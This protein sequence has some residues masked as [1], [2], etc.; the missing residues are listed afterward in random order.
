MKIKQKEKLTLTH[1]NWETLEKIR[2]GVEFVGKGSLILFKEATPL[3]LSGLP[4][5][6]PGN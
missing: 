2:E 1:Q 4:P 5:Q 6:V 3:A